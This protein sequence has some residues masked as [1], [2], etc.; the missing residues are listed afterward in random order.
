LAA[1][2]ILDPTLMFL[3]GQH[4]TSYVASSLGLLWAASLLQSNACKSPAFVCQGL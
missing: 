2:S 1:D 3:V 4:G